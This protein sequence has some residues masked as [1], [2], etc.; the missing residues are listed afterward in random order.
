MYLQLTEQSAISKASL[1]LLI[2]LAITL[3]LFSSFNGCG[4][5]Q[6]PPAKKDTGIIGK[7]TKE[8]GEAKPGEEQADMQAKG[9]TAVPGAYGYAVAQTSKL[10][11]KQ[12]VE[13]YRAAEGEY[14]KDYDEFMEK[15]IKQNGIE[16][17]V[18]PG[19]RQ[20]KYDVENHEL[21]VVE[22]EQTE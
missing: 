7:K 17:P 22:K 11:I 10:Q 6:T 12:A 5:P 16:L 13:L 3:V 14:P 15:I 2:K 19:E 1:T 18:L 20:Y 4:E 8:I 9:M 21:I